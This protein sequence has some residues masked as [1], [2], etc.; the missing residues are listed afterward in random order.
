[1]YDSSEVEIWNDKAYKKI[2]GNI[3][4]N[5]IK[6]ALLWIIVLEFLVGG[7]AYAS[8]PGVF[9]FSL[10][11]KQ[12]IQEPVMEANNTTGVY[13]VRT[14][15]ELRQAIERA[16]DGD[17]ILFE[18]DISASSTEE[19]FLPQ[20]YRK[21]TVNGN[22]HTINFNYLVAGFSLNSDAVN[23]TPPKT[24]ITFKNLTFTKGGYQSAIRAQGMNAI[25]E[26][27][28]F[29]GNGFDE[30]KY[31]SE[32]KEY[33]DELLKPV[34]LMPVY[35][36]VSSFQGDLFI[37]DCTFYNNTL[38]VIECEEGNAEITNT[39]IYDNRVFFTGFDARSFTPYVMQ[40]YPYNANIRNTTIVSNKFFNFDKE[41]IDTSTINI[42]AGVNKQNT[43][44]KFENRTISYNDAVALSS[45]KLSTLTTNSIVV[46]NNTI[47]GNKAGIEGYLTL[48]GNIIVANTEKDIK[49]NF[50]GKE[51]G[52]G[53]ELSE[54]NSN[55]YNLIGVTSAD[56]FKS[57][58][59]DK[60]G[61]SAIE[62]FETAKPQV[63]NNG[64]SVPT[65]L[66]RN[67][68]LA[69]NKIPANTSW[70]L[71]NDA[72]GTKRPQGSFGDIG[73]IELDDKGST[74]PKDPDKNGNSGGCNVGVGFT[75]ATL[76]LFGVLRRKMSKP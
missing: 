65:I 13:V 59:S 54:V 61:V 11:T 44:V 40:L 34:W 67:G 28:K 31:N 51:G 41:G 66:I 10:M 18:S 2:G 14:W 57:H 38:G 3:L 4:K 23:P 39:H 35:G 50:M 53:F 30:T 33:Y 22:G 63:E 19:N 64:G 75:V 36:V 16:Q 27:C 74:D 62:V 7:A 46:T 69:H 1:V 29:I 37:T 17:E 48:Q 55:G 47:V 45:G 20:L 12:E 24:T 76:A 58:T 68:G 52:M 72:R 21:I 49:R 32:Y 25:V 60:T 73:A 70:L 5:L 26:N 43:T 6:W 71:P 9:G 8:T 56:V 15:N 42:V